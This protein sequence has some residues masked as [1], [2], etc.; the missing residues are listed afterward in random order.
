MSAH[1][2]YVTGNL[3]IGMSFNEALSL[4]V[5]LIR[6]ATEYGEKLGIVTMTENH[7]YAF[8]DADRVE[9]VYNTVNHKNFK[10]LVDIGNFTCADEDPV[11]SVS[12]VANLAA[13]VHLKDFEMIPFDSN[14]SK[15]NTFMTRG[16][17]Y[18]RGVAVGYG[19]VKTVQCINILKKAGYD[20]YLDIEFEGPEDCI[21]ELERGLLLVRSAI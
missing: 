13:H 7:G 21:T 14:A 18:L 5:P 12:R 11:K 19:D 10:L 20:G 15:E 4:T 2:P 6:A 16:C 3:P 9:K 8:Q 1:I 17:N